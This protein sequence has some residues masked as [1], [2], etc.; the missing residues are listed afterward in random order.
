MLMKSLIPGATLIVTILAA[1]ING[2]LDGTQLLSL[3]LWAVAGVTILV[4][5]IRA[6][7]TGTEIDKLCVVSGYIPRSPAFQRLKTSKHI[8]LFQFFQLLPE[9]IHVFQLSSATTLTTARHRQAR[10][11]FPIQ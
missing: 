7:I 8:V 11:S 9:C 10:S 2:A 1:L 3:V 6:Y 4:I 5:L